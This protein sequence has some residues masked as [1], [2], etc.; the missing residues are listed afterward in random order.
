MR[1]KV[2]IALT[3]LIFLGFVALNTSAQEDEPYLVIGDGHRYSVESVAF[4]PDGNTLASGSW[5]DTIKL[6]NPRTGIVLKTLEGHTG[7][8][9]SVAFHP[10]GNTLASASADETIKLWNANTG[11]LL[12]TLEGHTYVAFSPDGNTLASGS[13]DY[14][15]K[16]WDANTGVVLR[17]LEGHTAGVS[18]VAFHPDGNTIAS[19]SGGSKWGKQK[20]NTIR[21]WDADTGELLNT[22]EGH[23][24]SVTSVAFYPDGNTIASGSLDGTIKLWDVKTGELLKTLT[25]HHGDGFNSVAFSPDGNTIA[26]GY[27]TWASG[28]IRLWDANTGELLNTLTGHTGAVSSVAFSPDGQ[29]LASSSGDIRLWN[30]NTGEL[31]NTLTR[32]KISVH[33]VAFHPDGNI[34]AS[35]N[36]NNTIKLWNANTGELLNTLT[37]H[38][39]AVSSVAFGPDGNKIASGSLGLWHNSGGT[40]RLWDANTGE[41]LNTLTGHTHWVSS[42]AFH[43]D[44]NTIASGS[45]DKTIRLWDANTGEELNTLGGHTGDVYSVAFSPDGNKIASASADETIKLWNANT[46]ELLKTIGGNIRLLGRHTDDVVSVAFSPDGN[47]IASGSHDNTIKLWD[48][49]IGEL[50]NTLTGHTELVVTVAFSPDGNT[51]ASASRDQTIKLWNANTGEL[52]NTLTGHTELVESVAFSPDGHTIASAGQDG[53]IRLWHVEPAAPTPKEPRTTV[54]LSKSSIVAPNKAFTLDAILENTGGVSAAATL[55]FYGPVKVERTTTQA[56]SGTLPAI[57]FTDKTLGEPIDIAAMAV[58]STRKET[59]TTTAPATAGTYA[60]KACIQRADGAGG[61]DEICSDVFTVTIAP[62]D[63]QFVKVWA[64]PATVAPGAAFKLYATVSNAG[65]KSDR[66]TLW[67]YSLGASDNTEEPEELQGTRIDSLPMADGKTVVTKHITVTAPEEP[68]TYTYRLS[69]DSVEGEEDTDNNSSDFKITVALGGPDLV[70]ESVQASHLSGSLDSLKLGDNEI[71]LSATVKNIGTAKSDSTTLRFYRSANA[72]LSI[73]DTKIASDVEVPPLNPQ[74]TFIHSINTTAGHA[75]KYPKPSIYYFGVLVGSPSNEIN[76]DNN[77]SVANNIVKVI[78]DDAALEGH[79]S[80]LRLNVPQNFI[81]EVAYSQGYTYFLLTAQCLPVAAS[82]SEAALDPDLYTNQICTIRLYLPSDNLSRDPVDNP[83]Y[84]M[85][86]VEVPRDKLGD[87]AEEG[88]GG[89][90]KSV[91]FTALG[92]L[93]GEIVKSVGGIFFA[94]FTTGMEVGEIIMNYHKTHAEAEAQTPTVA[95][96]DPDKAQLCLFLIPGRLSSVEISILQK[97][98]PVN[99][100]DT[101]IG[102]YGNIWNLEETWRLENPDVAAAPGAPSMSLTDYPLFQYLPPEVQAYIL[103]YFGEDEGMGVVHPEA[104][105]IPQQTSLLPNYPNPFNPETWI[106]YQLAESAEVSLT[107]YDIQGRVVWD[108]D[109]GHQRAGTYRARSRAAYWDGRN[110]QG[111]PVASGV[112]FYTLKAGDFS[113][114]RKMLIRK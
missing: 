65:G 26:S 24:Y 1:N 43:P 89:V 107:I 79:D 63:L 72:H 30:A 77:W 22:L 114:T 3:L 71:T 82:G 61:T 38:T 101:L 69:I 40:I 97:L 13:Q 81:S 98:T 99:T 47:K 16:L 11:E 75:T 87:I 20:D 37:G 92:E 33:G 62:P 17:T 44:G 113:A 28:T 27:G 31:L 85:F 58:D 60:Y 91:I 29:T 68:G 45:G 46:G 95:L 76:A 35:A 56:T 59:I 23:T 105:Q 66:T 41:E 84:F 18:S 52:L 67:W 74:E 55:Q 25:G 102:A 14:T 100:D 111:E 53:T 54:S 10:D 5:D 106:P 93:A 21:L 109:L 32:H 83:A 7:V 64:E 86:H 48:V 49:N 12:R 96:E 110:A 88:A 73:D 34:I 42:V 36:H 108:L 19:G 50:L 6:W 70:I 9:W 104:L 8:V 2:K 15:I 112:Y 78:V 39:G 80:R 51:L 90:F 4:H 94:S 57:D 103:R